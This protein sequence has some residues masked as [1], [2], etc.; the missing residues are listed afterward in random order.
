AGASFSWHEKI[1]VAA[2]AA[3]SRWSEVEELDPPDRRAGVEITPFGGYSFQAG[4]RETA[5]QR[6]W[7]MGIRL[8]PKRGQARLDVGYQ[9]PDDDRGD[10]SLFVS[11]VYSP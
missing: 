11:Y 2:Q 9:W 5:D 10:K 6:F 1:T 4:R 3:A 7:T 8:G